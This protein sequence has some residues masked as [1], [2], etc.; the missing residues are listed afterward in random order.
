MHLTDAE[1]GGHP[2][3]L[4]KTSMHGT[5]NTTN[6]LL[7]WPDAQDYFSNTRKQTQKNVVDEEKT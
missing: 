1:A 2:P 4:K 5:R 6:S 3:F 7:L